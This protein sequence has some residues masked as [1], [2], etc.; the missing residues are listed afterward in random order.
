[1]SWGR[2]VGWDDAWPD[3]YNENQPLQD[4]PDRLACLEPADAPHAQPRPAITA[5]GLPAALLARHRH[6]SDGTP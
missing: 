6:E 1:M 4:A 2:W 5:A 3:L